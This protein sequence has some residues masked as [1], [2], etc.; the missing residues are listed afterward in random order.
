MPLEAQG[1]R[2]LAAQKEWNNV[3]VNLNISSKGTEH[4]MLIFINV[5]QNRKMPCELLYE[6]STTL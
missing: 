4:L 1:L 3:S 6:P 5:L 2:S